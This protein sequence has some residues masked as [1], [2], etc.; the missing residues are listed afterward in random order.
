M[1]GFSDRALILLSNLETYEECGFTYKYDY[2]LAV[3]NLINYLASVGVAHDC[4]ITDRLAASIDMRDPRWLATG[5]PEDMFFMQSYCGV[6]KHGTV[7]LDDTTLARLRSK[8]PI[9]RGLS[10]EDRF[11]I[12][13]KRVKLAE[14]VLIESYPVVVVFGQEFKVKSKPDDGRAILRIHEKKF[15]TSMELSGM[16]VPINDFLQIPYANQCLSEWGKYHVS[17]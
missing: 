13:A 4:L 14:R 12:V 6:P 15:Y 11:P 10:P 8:F 5:A 16:E 9:E 1:K 7:P 3:K 17:D 2:K